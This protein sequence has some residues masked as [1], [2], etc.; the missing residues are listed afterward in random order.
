MSVDHISSAGKKAKGERPYF[1]ASEQTEQLLNITMALAQELAVTRERLDTVERLLEQAN[2]VSQQDIN[3][4]KPDA[5]AADERQAWHQE[6]IA[7]ILRI[8]QQSRE[9]IKENSDGQP[10]MDEVVKDICS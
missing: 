2:L 8:V 5:V 10:P 1:L 6:Y 4:Y 9:A 7:R 3:A